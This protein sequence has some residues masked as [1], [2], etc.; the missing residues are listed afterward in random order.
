[1][2]LTYLGRPVRL[3]TRPDSDPT[4]L[5]WIVYVDDPETEAWVSQSD[6]VEVSS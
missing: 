4:C 2:T 6:L 3:V 1:M 5:V